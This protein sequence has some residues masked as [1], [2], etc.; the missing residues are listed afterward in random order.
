MKRAL[1]FS[2]GG[3][4]GAYEI[5]AWRALSEMGLRFQGVYGTSIG[6]INALLFAQGDLDAALRIWENM[7][8]EQVTAVKKE[9]FVAVDNMISRKRDLLPFLLEHANSLRMDISPLERLMRENIDEGRVRASGLILGLMTVRFPSLAPA[10]VRLWEV[11]EGRLVDWALASASCFPIFPTRAIDGER[12]VDGGYADNLPVDMAIQD[13]AQEIV[14]VDVH[15]KPT[16]PEYLPLPM[17]TSITPLKPLG[18]FLD[19]EPARLRRSILLG[20]QDT[21]TRFERL[22]GI[23]YTFLR[24]PEL[25]LQRL[26]RRYVQAV[27]AFDARAISRQ[28]LASQPTVAPLVSVLASDAPGRQLSWKETLLRGLELAALCAGAE[29][30]AVYDPAELTRRVRDLAGAGEA[31]EPLTEKR[32]EALAHQGDLPLLGYLYRYLKANGDFDDA[33]IRLAAAHPS[34]TAA[35]LYLAIAGEAMG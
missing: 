21:M 9:D 28:S 33:D 35:A 1:V 12:Y 20:Y 16:H 15:P 2:G 10:P 32:L 31:P 23:R 13:G 19:F 14:A 4:R 6:A 27:S 25:R 18:G 24:Q 3:S 26:A 34:Q 11:P 8:V 5:G 30:C 22:D 7:T 17:L 29:E